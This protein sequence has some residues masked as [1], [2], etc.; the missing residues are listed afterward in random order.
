[1][2]FF[3]VYSFHGSNFFRQSRTDLVGSLSLMPRSMECTN[4]QTS[5]KVCNALFLL[6]LVPEIVCHEILCMFVFV[7]ACMLCAAPPSMNPWMQYLQMSHIR[8]CRYNFTA[9]GD[10]LDCKAVGVGRLCQVSPK[11][12]FSGGPHSMD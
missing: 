9:R 6:P 5:D 4:Q 11:C 7:C 3:P 1:M 12:L 10:I 2:S 8:P